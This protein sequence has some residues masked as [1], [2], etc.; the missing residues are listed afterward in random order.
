MQDADRKQSVRWPNKRRTADTSHQEA[1]RKWQATEKKIRH[2]SLVF[3]GVFGK[4]RYSPV[5]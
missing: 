4:T 1:A 3:A 5:H 2:F